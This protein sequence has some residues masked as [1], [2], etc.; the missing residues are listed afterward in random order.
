MKYILLAI[1]IS[2]TSVS[3]FAQ[4][5]T[6]LASSKVRQFTV[7]DLTPE[8]RKVWEN[9]NAIVA[10]TRKNLL[11]RMFSDR[12]LEAE[13]GSRKTTSSDLVKREMAKLQ[14]PSE[15]QIK[16]IYEANRV[17]LQNKPLEDVRLQII[18]FLRRE[19]E[20]KAL[21][22]YVESLT[23]KHKAAYGKDVNSPGLNPMEMLF[24]VAGRSVSA[25]E[26]EQIN[27]R[28]LNEV[29]AEIVD[30]VKHDLE[31]VALNEL[32]EVEARAQ[33]T[34]AGTLFGREI[35]DKMRDFSDEERAGLEND[36][37]RKLFAKYELR[38]LVKEPEPFVENVS[39]DDDPAFGNSAAP[40]TVIMFSDFQCSAC[41]KTHPILKG[42]IDGYGDKV[43]F[44][45]RDFP[46]TDIHENAFR[47]AVAANAAHKQGKFVA[48]TERLYTHQDALD[49]ASLK[50]YA[51]ELGLNAARFELD[52]NDEKAAA[53]ISKD[54]ADGKSYGVKGTPTIFINGIKVRHLSAEDFRE[55]IDVALKK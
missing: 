18:G 17:N 49:T 16:A 43:R 35:T 51:A 52:L 4:S 15:I 22:N 53:E 27:K 38:F 45:V 29:R 32:I 8:A 5:P 1:I 9:Q 41:A 14:Q 40:V 54:I 34:D 25:R 3:S 48:F 23:T 44:V 30:T 19:P 11:A 6:V 24:S 26:F 7:S 37:K 13:A 47:A 31:V 28:D 42:V 12:V 2:I 46:L 36:L 39:I 10:D 21:K 55:L 33:K 50:R 20:E